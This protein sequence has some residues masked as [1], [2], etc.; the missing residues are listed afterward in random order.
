MK[1]EYILYTFNMPDVEDP[2]LHVSAPIYEWQQTPEGK[3][4]MDHA[5]DPKYHIRPDDHSF[6]YKVTLTGKLKD[7]YA[8]LY[9]LKQS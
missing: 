5:Q 6:G 7:K 4:A 2:D 1:N 8:T 9:A 3:W